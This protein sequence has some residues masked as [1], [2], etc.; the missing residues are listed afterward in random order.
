MATTKEIKEVLVSDEISNLINYKQPPVSN[1]VTIEV[2]PND[3]TDLVKSHGY[4]SINQQLHDLK[5]AGKNY[6]AYNEEMY[7]HPDGVVNE[8]WEVPRTLRADYDIVD[9]YEDQIFF[10]KVYQQYTN[11]MEAGSAARKAEEEAKEARMKKLE[12]ALQRVEEWESQRG[13]AKGS[14]S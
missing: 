12:A 8:D 4:K 3:M 7:T 10:E 11:L 5:V 9:Q 2:A 1:I 13:S 14:E 6:E